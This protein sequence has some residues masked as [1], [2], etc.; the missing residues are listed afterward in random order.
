MRFLV[1]CPENG[2]IKEIICNIGTDSSKKDSLQ[3]FHVEN[4]VPEG[5]KNKVDRWYSLKN[6]PTRMIIARNNGV[7]QLTRRKNI[8]KRDDERQVEYHTS[9]FE[10]LDFINDDNLL[11]DS[12][13]EPLFT[14][15]K[16]RTKLVDEFI[17]ITPLDENETKF[18]VG[19][20]S[21]SIHILELNCA[22]TNISKIITHEVTP[23]LEFV[24][25]Y[26]NDNSNDKT[27]VF[28]IG[29]EE[30]LIKLY[31]LNEDLQT[32]S[33]IWEAKN[34]KNDRLDMR[35]PVW[36]MSLKFLNPSENIKQKDQINYQFITITR[37]SHLGIYQ[38]QHGKKPLHYIDLLSNRE[39]LTSL[40]L[41][42]DDVNKLTP[43]GNLRSSDITNFNFVTTDTKHQVL[44]YTNTGK[45][46]G[47]FGK[48]DIVGASNYIHI[49]PNK[50]L[51]VQVGLDRYLRVFDV[52][53]LKT[54]IR[55]YIGSKSNF[56]ELIDE[57]D[58]LLPDQTSKNSTKKSKNGSA[59][60]TLAAKEEEEEDDDPESLW[61]ELE[62]GTNK[63]KKS[64]Q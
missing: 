28:A 54:L 47:K 10:M 36:P 21:G 41:I 11:N 45:L 4:C 9:E 43:L 38:T 12:V 44:K 61:E 35:I 29:G 32:L 33:K 19:T 22:Y 31:K 57:D 59:K 62:R 5:S 53:S 3:P 2:S 6:D 52:K 60:R 55:V 56:V 20:K 24:Q 34:V 42:D 16:K 26:D 13:L 58:I 40:E 14:K 46:I 17:C 15:S 50:N 51:L 8:L 30:N 37:Y 23:P 27:H 1:G 25:L 7:I 63:V 39:P 18:I 64:K 49:I 48:S